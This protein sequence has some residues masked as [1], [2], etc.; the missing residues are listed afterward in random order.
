MTSVFEAS[1]HRAGHR[2]H[3]RYL[4][5]ELAGEGG[6]ARVYR[7]R[8]ELLGRDVAVKV[9]HPG[10]ASADRLRNLSETRLLASLS[11]P[12]LVTLFDAHLADPGD[13]YLVMEYLDGPTL[14]ERIARGPIGGRDLA[15]MAVELADAL[16]V[17]H[18]AGIVHRDI[19]PS[20][21]ILR[22]I[23]SRDR[24]FR[25]TLT[26][27]GI[28]H[29]VDSARV[30]ATGTVLGTAAYLS[31]EQVRGERPGPGSDVYAL[32]LV[33]L[34]AHTRRP[35]FGEAS[36]PET[37]AARLVRQPDIP[38]SLGDEWASLLAAMTAPRPE[39][40]PTA[41]EVAERAARLPTE[42]VAGGA[43]AP[44]R[45]MTAGMVAGSV[46][47]SPV[48]AG[49]RGIRARIWVPLLG[50]AAAVVLAAAVVT[51]SLAAMPA[52][53]PAPL[54]SASTPAPSPTAVVS[55]PVTG[56]NQGEDNGNVTK[57]NKGPGSSNG[58]RDKGNGKD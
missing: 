56:G 29:L 16:S 41:R 30:T 12:S 8:D 46:A 54:V 24:T 28:A 57:G 2:L 49:R 19:K 44:T 14:R 37:L 45:P 55:V 34:E 36:V 27:F 11:H 26:D 47:A 31:P 43:T 51:V 48:D 17:V 4:I 22:S 58:N 32:G 6:M 23:R 53:T 10:S 42:A 35:A 13:A 3:G 39:A 40:R 7:A 9:F 18:A 52:G 50:G 1:G 20:N 5:E 25:A 33:L 38:A 21:V 15:G